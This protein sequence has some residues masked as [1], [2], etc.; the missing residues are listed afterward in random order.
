MVYRYNAINCIIVSIIRGWNVTL[1]Y[2]F[3][4]HRFKYCIIF[5]QFEYDIS[6][7]TL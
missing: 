4:A 5:K 6:V 7:I 2:K 1:I 3:Q